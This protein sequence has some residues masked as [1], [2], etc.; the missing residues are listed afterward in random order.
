V[1][2]LVL[3]TGDARE[4]AA[5]LLGKTETLAGGLQITTVKEGSGQT[6]SVSFVMP[7]MLCV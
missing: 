4:G 6:A 1:A 2:A 7:A 5:V 3:V